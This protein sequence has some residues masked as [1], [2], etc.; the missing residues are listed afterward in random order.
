MKGSEL[1]CGGLSVVSERE[2]QCR[3]YVRYL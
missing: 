3:Y 2:R 1:A